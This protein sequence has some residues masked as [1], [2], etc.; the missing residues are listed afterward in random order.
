M[1]SNKPYS[2]ED[3]LEY[4]QVLL[5]NSTGDKDIL[6]FNDS[7]V[8]AELVASYI[9]KHSMSDDKGKKNTKVNMYC[10]K[11]SLFRDSAKEKI[12]KIRQ[13]VKPK[14]GKDGRMEKWESFKPYDALMN[15]LEAYM[16]DGG[17]LNVI[18]ET[19]ISEITTEQSWNILRKYVQNRQL[20][21]M[22][23]SAQIGLPHFIEAGNSYRIENNDEQKTA[24]CCFNDKETCEMLNSNFDLLSVMS[25][26]CEL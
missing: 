10:G 8:H 22:K 23:L 16:N 11:F 4:E 7:I 20:H 15:S 18:V 12:E 14:D 13:E 3:Y 21:F 5:T 25:N 24:I 1:E 19:P 26:D 17:H 6:I 9:F 2:L